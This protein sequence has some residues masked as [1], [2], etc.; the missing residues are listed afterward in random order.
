MTRQHARCSGAANLFVDFFG[1]G[2]FELGPFLMFTAS[3]PKLVSQGRSSARR[4]RYRGRGGV[5]RCLRPVDPPGA[6]GGWQ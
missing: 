2:P 6:Y 4:R 3:R 1:H 5:H